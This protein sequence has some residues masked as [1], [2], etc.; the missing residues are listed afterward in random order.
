MHHNIL[1]IKNQD[2]IT[3]AHMLK[4]LNPNCD[5]TKIMSF[6]GFSYLHSWKKNWKLQKKK[7]KRKPM[8]GLSSQK[9]M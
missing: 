7:S 8:G 6:K 9:Q 5:N 2:V 4:N 3:V 1:N